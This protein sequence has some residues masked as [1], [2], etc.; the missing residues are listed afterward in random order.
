M[1]RPRFSHLADIIYRK[2]PIEKMAGIA[3]EIEKNL[4]DFAEAFNLYFALE[5]ASMSAPN[6]SKKG[7]VYFMRDTLS[8]EV[9]IGFSDGRVWGR[10]KYHAN[11][12]ERGWELD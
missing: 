4:P 5:S 12:G 11:H 8:G 10:A 9:K 1:I 2:Y 6:Q 3:V 7:T